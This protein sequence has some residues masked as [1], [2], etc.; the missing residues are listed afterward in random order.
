MPTFSPICCGIDLIMNP[1][2]A[3]LGRP[4]YRPKK[5]EQFVGYAVS[6]C[7]KKVAGRQARPTVYSWAD[8]D[9]FI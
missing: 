3:G 7:K 4:A 5:E 1:A 6:G 2:S 8:Q 9:R